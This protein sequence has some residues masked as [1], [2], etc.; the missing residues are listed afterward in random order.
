MKRKVDFEWLAGGEEEGEWETIAQTERHRWLRVLDTV[1]RRAWITLAVLVFALSVTTFGAVRYA[2]LEAQRKI[3]FQIQNVI[4]TEA[5]AF[6]QGDKVRFLAQQDSAAFG[7]YARQAMR[8]NPNCTEFEAG[9]TLYPWQT[10]DNDPLN[11]CAPVLPA[12]ILHVNLQQDVAWVEVLEGQPPVRRMRFYR[13]TARGWVHTAP[14]ETFWQTPIRVR[15]GNVFVTYHKR[16]EPYIAL[17]EARIG[18]VVGDTC[19]VVMH[20][21][22]INKIEI[23]FS[24]Q[25]PAMMLSDP[26][27]ALEQSGTLTLSSPW[28]SGI[29][30]DGP[31]GEAMLD[32]LA[33]WVAYGMIAKASSSVAAQDINQ[34]QRAIA[35]EYAAWY[36]SQDMAQAPLLGRVVE[37]HGMEALP[38]VFFSLKGARIYT[39]FMMRW[40][41]LSE[42]MGEEAFFELLLTIEREAILAGRKETFLLFQGGAWIEERKRAFDEMRLAGPELGPI[43]IKA[44]E[45]VGDC[46]RVTLDE[47]AASQGSGSEGTVS[48][49]AGQ[50]Q[51]H[52]QNRLEFFCLHDL[53]WERAP[54]FD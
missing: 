37:R 38:E 54:P 35:D 23:D 6:A 28:L 17:L 47:V 19:A 20:C 12:E 3:T 43:R 18:Q 49:K 52:P 10:I 13:Q 40:I 15:H 32:S 5:R 45:R 25:T 2:Y 50:G 26:R 8:I 36:G 4:D 44:V 29:P 21:A 42:W 9:G 53:F 31:F 24:T 22:A 16:D 51:M 27:D 34:L 41:G 14:D 33:Y 7:W 48:T 46:A 39:L 11:R 30:V 1:S